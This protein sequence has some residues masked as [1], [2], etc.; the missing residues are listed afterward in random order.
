V[1]HSVSQPASD[2]TQLGLYFANHSGGDWRGST[3]V[4]RPASYGMPAGT[5]ELVELDT[6]SGAQVGAD[7]AQFTFGGGGAESVQ[8]VIPGVAAEGVRFL[9]IRPLQ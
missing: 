8:L 9:V 3:S 5:Y 1:L 2:P 6:S 7:L 4:L